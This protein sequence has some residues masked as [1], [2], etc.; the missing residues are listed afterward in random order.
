[1]EKLFG[2]SPL[3]KRV[4]KKM[5]VH[6]LPSARQVADIKRLVSLVAKS[7]TSSEARCRD[8]EF[9]PLIA[10]SEPLG[11]ERRIFKDQVSN[12]QSVNIFF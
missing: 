7:I 2:I 12:L 4:T 6:Q 11:Q 1:M 5:L 8:R 10:S 9:V 3:T